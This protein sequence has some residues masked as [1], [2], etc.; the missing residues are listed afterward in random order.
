M[1]LGPLFTAKETGRT[2]FPP[3]GLIPLKRVYDPEPIEEG[4]D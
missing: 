4:E 1:L 3:K 2:P